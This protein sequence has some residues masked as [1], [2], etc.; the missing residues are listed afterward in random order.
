[1]RYTTWL[2]SIL[3]LF[4]FSLI[5]MK[6]GTKRPLK[7]ISLTSTQQ[8]KKQ[9][10][11]ISNTN[12]DFTFAQ[13]QSLKEFSIIIEHYLGNILCLNNEY[14]KNKKRICTNS[15]VIPNNNHQII[16]K[17]NRKTIS[18]KLTLMLPTAPEN[19]IFNI[20]N[21][22]IHYGDTINFNDNNKKELI[23]KNINTNSIILTL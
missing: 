9:K 7:N 16:L 20:P 19:I 6:L 1:M 11:N 15:C 10:P 17:T 23:I 5:S 22:Q 3:L 18:N 21:D 14:D 8:N 12:Q 2:L 13:E 4:P